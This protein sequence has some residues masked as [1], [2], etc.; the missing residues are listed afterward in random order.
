VF[1]G[2]DGAACYVEA[3]MLLKRVLL[4]IYTTLGS[5]SFSF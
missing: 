4:A 5:I 1:L 2:G 3:G